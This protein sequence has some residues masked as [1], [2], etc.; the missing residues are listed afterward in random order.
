MPL[1]NTIYIPYAHNTN[2]P[3][4]NTALPVNNEDNG[5][6]YH[7]TQSWC[8]SIMTQAVD[9][10]RIRGLGTGTLTNTRTH[11]HPTHPLDSNKQH[12][13]YTTKQKHHTRHLPNKCTTKETYLRLLLL[14]LQRNK[15]NRKVS[16]TLLHIVPYSKIFSHGFAD[17]SASMKIRTTIKFDMIS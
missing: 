5:H 12:V 9:C 15:N 11:S 6:N 7:N 8:I 3:H 17:R 2:L 4:G 1:Q 16:C 10:V 14:Y 13:G